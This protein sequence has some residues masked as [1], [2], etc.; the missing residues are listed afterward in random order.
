[1]L[2]KQEE[3]LNE[4]LLRHLI[5]IALNKLTSERENVRVVLTEKAAKGF[6]HKTL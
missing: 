5:R 3:K 4:V 6:P 2:P 1:M